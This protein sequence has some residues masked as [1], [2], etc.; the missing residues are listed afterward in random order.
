MSEWTTWRKALYDWLHES[1]GLAVSWAR[2]G[3]PRLPYPHG[4]LDVIAEAQIGHD[5]V[6][7]TLDVDSGKLVP[8]VYGNRVVTVQASIYTIQPGSTSTAPMPAREY[9]SRART[10]LRMPNRADAF[11][12][13]G[14]GLNQA[15]G[16]V[17]LDDNDGDRWLS[18][19]IMDVT[20]NLTSTYTDPLVVDDYIET[21]ESAGTLDNNGQAIDLDDTYGVGH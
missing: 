16:T 9:L 14:L 18:V 21:V 5:E 6:R 2:Q 17:Q 10:A 7:R 1:T 15:L 12:A 3:G 8:T 4:I 19:A 11:R 13:V 20:F